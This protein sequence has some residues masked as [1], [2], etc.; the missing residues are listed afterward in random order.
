VDVPALVSEFQQSTIALKAAY[1]Q[2]SQIK[3]LS[4]VNFLR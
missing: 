4:L 1:S 3:S 2:I